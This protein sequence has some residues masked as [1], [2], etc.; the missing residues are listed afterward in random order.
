MTIGYPTSGDPRP[1]RARD[2]PRYSEIPG[3]CSVLD[4]PISL[5]AG[6]VN[7]DGGSGRCRGSIIGRG[8]IGSSSSSS[9]SRDVDDLH[10]SE[11]LRG[12]VG[13]ALSSVA[14]DG[15]G[16]L[17][18]GCGIREGQ[19][20]GLPRVMRR[21]DLRVDNVGNTVEQQ[22]IGE[23][24][25][26]TVHPSTSILSNSKSQIGALKAG[27]ADVGQAG[28]EEDVVDDVV[29]QDLLEGLEI[30]ARKNGTDVLKGRVVG[31]EHSEVGYVE[32][33]GGVGAD[34]AKV[35][36][37]LSGVHGGVEVEQ[38]VA[39]GEQLERRAEAE[40]RVD[41]VDDDRVANFDVLGM[42]SI[43]K[44]RE[45]LLA[46]DDN[47]IV[48]VL[49]NTVILTASEVAKGLT[50][51]DKARVEERLDKDRNIASNLGGIVALEDVVGQKSANGDGVVAL[52]DGLAL[53][54]VS[55]D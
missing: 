46:R 48:T 1:G 39:A 45:S 18:D 30:S 38:V 32:Q 34:V 43:K 13:L 24:D 47:N 7:T 2:P 22:S 42:V 25:L 31:D 15:E 12:G 52:L 55:R 51:V 23:K 14:D 36:G 20:Y 50:I 5:G 9:K 27:N 33:V 26:G 11:K 6:S 3:M 28:G 21:Y 4:Y 10:G 49:H 17:G 40:R 53:G 35:V 8:C 41:L 19:A 29:L 16:E 37:Q 44:V 54:N